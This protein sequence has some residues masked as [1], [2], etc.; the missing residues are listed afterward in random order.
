MQVPDNNDK[1]S[2]EVAGASTTS[3][4][5]KNYYFAFVRWCGKLIAYILLMA[6]GGLYGVGAYKIF[7]SLFSSPQNGASGLMLTSFLA[8]IPLCIGLLTGHIAKKKALGGWITA[9][10]LSALSIALFVFAAGALLREGMICI[11]MAIPLFIIMGVLGAICG[12]IFSATNKNA[13]KWCSAFLLLPLLLGTAEQQITPAAT[14]QIIQK[15]ILINASPETI[16]QLINHPQDIHPEELKSGF[17]YRI[18]VPFP[19]QATTL[20]GKVGGKRELVWQRGI[21]FEEEITAWE[22]N[23]HIAWTYKF[24]ADS[25]PSGSLDDH[26]VIGGKYFN[27]EDTSYTLTP[28]A[29]GTRLQIKVKTR[30]STNFNWYAEGWANFLV[31]DTART[32]LGFYKNRAENIN[33]STSGKSK[34][35]EPKA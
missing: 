29:H 1:E 9:S 33:T 4:P 31:G 15:D 3:S 26:I 12:L 27:L 35:L 2:H 18:G 17:A 7:S 20:E 19:I 14:T 25:F 8:G 11:V 24:N 30:V 32:I 5:E 28:E 10:G 13:G 22:L 16:W 21:T 34:I 23:R 6:V